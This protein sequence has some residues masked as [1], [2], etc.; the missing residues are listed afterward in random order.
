MIPPGAVA[1]RHAPGNPWALLSALLLA[2]GVVQVIQG[3]REEGWKSKL[4]PFIL[5]ALTIVA[6]AATTNGR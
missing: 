1:G 6:G 3:I 4:L 2:T 5:G